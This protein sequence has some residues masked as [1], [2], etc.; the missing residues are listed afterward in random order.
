LAVVEPNHFLCNT[1]SN[2][3]EMQKRQVWV[4]NP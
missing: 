4:P 1:P 3:P 2:H